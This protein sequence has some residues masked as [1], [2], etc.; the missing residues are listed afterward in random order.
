MGVAGVVGEMVHSH[1]QMHHY[2]TSVPCGFS[3]ILAVPRQ[4]SLAL[5]SPEGF[6]I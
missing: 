6:R 5:S 3:H 4:F 1:I 2:L